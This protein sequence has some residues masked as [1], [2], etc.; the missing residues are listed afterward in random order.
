MKVFVYGAGAHGRVILETLKLSQRCS[1]VE[2][3]DDDQSLWGSEVN[4]TPVVGGWEYLISQDR[5]VFKV[6][7]GQGHPGLRMELARKMEEHSVRF[8]NAVH[9][10]A[11]VMRSTRIGVG[12]MIGATAVMTSNVVLG[13]HVILNTGAVV[14]HDC[15]LEDFTTICPGVQ[16][17]GRTRVRQGAFIC[18]G[19][20]VLPRITIGASSVVAAGSLVTKSVPDH[21]LV[22]GTPARIQTHFSETFDWKRLL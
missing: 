5:S 20:I 19:A 8:L 14:E 4:G 16:L 9:P 3:I 11:A 21:V 12:N 18:T 6:I 15:M 7:V 10:S 1:S 2:F 22:L 13:N 17:G